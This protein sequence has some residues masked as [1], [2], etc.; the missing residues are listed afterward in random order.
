[1]NLI[2]IYKAFGKASSL[3]SFAPLILMLIA[4]EKLQKFLRPVLIL[5]VLAVLV[6]MIS[7]IYNYYNVSNSLIFH[8]YTIVEFALLSM[9]Y[10]QFLKQIS[11][12]PVLFYVLIPVIATLGY[13][14]YFVS[15]PQNM[16]SI[17]AGFESIIL[18]A[19]SLF[20]YYHCLKK[21]NIKAIRFDEWFWINS[22]I[23]FY[24]G[25][26]LV[27]FAGSTMVLEQS[28]RSHLMYWGI[29]HSFCNI[30]YN[31]CLSLGFWKAKVK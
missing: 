3:S 4:F 5:V 21:S 16:G 11:I 22:G 2:E 12:R 28:E 29:I 20:C 8:V 9:F 6:E 30:L 31:F 17:T 15:E 23:M 13:Y 1:M 18:T 10:A 27:L 14:D 26:N 24:F 19:Y 7:W 25:G